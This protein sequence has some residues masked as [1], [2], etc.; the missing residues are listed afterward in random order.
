MSFS[1]AAASSQRCLLRVRLRWAV[2]TTDAGVDDDA[3]R[4][5]GSS[6]S[7]IIAVPAATTHR[8]GFLTHLTAA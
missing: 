2:F 6:T 1:L 3:S 5:F 7:K 4:Y 8:L